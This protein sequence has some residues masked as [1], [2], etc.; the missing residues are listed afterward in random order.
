MNG[1]L[2]EVAAVVLFWVGAGALVV[3][4]VIIR[5]RKLKAELADRAEAKA[6]RAKARE[7]AAWRAEYDAARER[8]AAEDAL[9]KLDE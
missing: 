3:R 9:R 6:L 1:A 4:Y 2:I 5:E 8:L 7:A